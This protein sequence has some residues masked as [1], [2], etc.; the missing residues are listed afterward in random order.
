M[1]AS[2]TVTT[3]VAASP[4]RAFEVFSRE[5]DLWWRRGQ[6]HRFLPSG[7]VLEF[8]GQKLLEHNP[9]TGDS[10]EVGRVLAWDPP[11]RLAFEWRLPSW[12]LYQHTEVEVRFEP[13]AGG[14]RVTITH[15]GYEDRPEAFKSQIALWWSDL[16]VIYRRAATVH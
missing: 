2:V 14:T 7:G 3:V 6:H 10:F 1:S 9:T 11:R 4:E 16:L 15:R 8:D 5:T 12:Q 13:V